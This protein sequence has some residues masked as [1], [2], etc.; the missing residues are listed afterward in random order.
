M[1][2]LQHDLHLLLSVWLKIVTW[3]VSDCYL[4]D[5][6]LGHEMQLAP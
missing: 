6:F 4:P 2:R 1:Q 3:C 5:Q